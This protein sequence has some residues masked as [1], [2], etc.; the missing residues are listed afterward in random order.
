MKD[1]PRKL[2]KQCHRTALHCTC[3][4]PPVRSS[5]LLAGINES[6]TKAWDT[7]RVKE[8][9]LQRATEELREATREWAGQYAIMREAVKQQMAANDQSSLVATT[10]P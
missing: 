3:G 1:R 5:D 4:V 2:C 6:E 10:E 9:Q 7:M 8:D